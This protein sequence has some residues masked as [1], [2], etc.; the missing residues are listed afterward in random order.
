MIRIIPKHEDK[1]VIDPS[2]GK[3]VPMEGI[4]ISKIT[5]FWKRRE[6]DGDVT[7]TKV[8]AKKPKKDKPKEG[9]K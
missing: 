4:V 6:K 2:T 9:E 5:T 7:I 3:K 8:I 1:K